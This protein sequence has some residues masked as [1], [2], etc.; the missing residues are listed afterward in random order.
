MYRLLS[1][2]LLWGFWVLPAAISENFFI[3]PQLNTVD[4]IDL[5]IDEAEIE[6]PAGDS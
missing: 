3:I 5:I 6:R 1:G 4:Q 2:H